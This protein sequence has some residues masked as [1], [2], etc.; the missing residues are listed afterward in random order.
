MEVI[1]NRILIV[2]ASCLVWSHIVS[3]QTISTE[4]LFTSSKK[5]VFD[6]PPAQKDLIIL[7]PSVPITFNKLEKDS[8]GIWRLGVAVSGGVGGT[9]ILGKA[10]KVEDKLASVDPWIYT[11]GSINYGV[12]Q[13]MSNQ[14]VGSLSISGFIGFSNIAISYSHDVLDGSNFWG[15]SLKFDV[16]SN[17]LPG[18]FILIKDLSSDK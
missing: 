14:A 4:G 2:V 1:M 17:L 16:L 8:A 13:N 15:I 18:A 6:V 5:A 9:F 3:A 10:T 12:K 11:G 7:L